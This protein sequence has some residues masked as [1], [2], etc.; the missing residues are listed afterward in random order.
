MRG[1]KIGVRF[2]TSISAKDRYFFDLNGFVVARNA[3]SEAEVQEIHDA[4][5]AQASFV[6]RTEESVRNTQPNSPMHESG[7]RKDCGGILRW[8]SPHCLPFRKLLAHPNLIPYINSFCGQGYRLDHQPFLISQ[9]PQSEGFHLHG[10]PITEAGEPNNFLQ[11][12]CDAK[13]N[14]W[15]TL[16]NMSVMLVKH[17]PGDGGLCF[18]RGSHKINFATP[19]EMIH[20]RLQE[21]SEHIYQPETNPGDVVFFSEATVHGSLA[22][23]GNRERRTILYRFAPPNCAYS[24]SYWPEREEF[25]D[26]TPEE[27]AVLLPPYHPRVDRPSLDVVDGQT[28]LI[29]SPRSEAKKAFDKQVFGV[30]YF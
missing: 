4:I 18:L 27:Q 8:P 30:N 13:G 28:K 14:I 10:G 20:G 15:T 26:C 11:Y 19:P 6:A 23:R 3:L 21:F 25:A 16:L 9:D 17:A 24:R 7:P 1:R 22:W 12:R 5:D 2:Y 29:N